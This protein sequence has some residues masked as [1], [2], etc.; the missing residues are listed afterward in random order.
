M[1]NLKFRAWDKELKMM[2]D[3]LKIDFGN[4]T[5]FYRHWLYGV[6]REIDIKE[7]IIMQATGA[8]YIYDEKGKEIFEG[9]IVKTRASEYGRF[10][11]YVDNAISRFQVRGVKQYK[12]LSVNL[13]GTCEIIGNIYENP[14]LLEDE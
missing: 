9:D 13:D 6:S 10:I 1:N 2:C 14:E 8:R 3:V 12:G 5:L 11:G 4:R 7:V